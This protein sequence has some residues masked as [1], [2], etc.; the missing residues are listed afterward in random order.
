MKGKQCNF[1]IWCLSC[2]IS[3]F[4]FILF[5]LKLLLFAISIGVPW[6]VS[7]REVS[8]SVILSFGFQFKGFWC[9]HTRLMFFTR[10]AKILVAYVT[11]W[12][13]TLRPGQ[14][15]LS[16]EIEGNKI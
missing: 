5:H 8:Q 7:T 10:T 4:I 14:E 1:V 6:C 12:L 9:N 16:R 13:L 3:K 11:S 2:V 15:L